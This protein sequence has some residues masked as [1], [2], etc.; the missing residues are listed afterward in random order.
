MGAISEFLGENGST[1]DVSGNVFDMGLE[2]LLLIFA[3]NVFAYIQMFEAF[4]CC[5][6]GPVAAC[7]LV[8]VDNGG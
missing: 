6:F 5:C 2:V 3:E 1:V 7:T 8:V 4:S